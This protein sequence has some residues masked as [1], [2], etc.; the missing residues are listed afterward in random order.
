MDCLPEKKNGIRISYDEDE[1]WEVIDIIINY[2]TFESNR[3][4]AFA[5]P[6]SVE[7]RD[8]DFEFYEKIW[9]FDPRLMTDKNI[10]WSIQIQI[11]S[12]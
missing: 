3:E 1:E 10:S 9:N 12:H 2:L 8:F 4:K 7:C 11:E 6:F 5:T